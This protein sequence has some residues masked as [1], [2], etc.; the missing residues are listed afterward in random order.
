MP[1]EIEKILKKSAKKKGLSG[2]KLNAYVY[3]TLK[4]KFGW[5]SKKNK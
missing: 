5:K 2:D 3:G 1:K 4:N